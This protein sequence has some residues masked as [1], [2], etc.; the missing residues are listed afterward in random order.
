MNSSSVNKKRIL[1]GMRPSGKL[2]VGHYWGALVNW[3][4][5]QDEY[6]CFYMVADWH[7]LTSEY[8]DTKD[9][10]SNVREMVIDW[11]AI[12]LDPQKSVIFRQ[13]AVKQHAELF[14]LLSMI[15]PLPWLERCP[16]YK[17]QLRE[18]TTR[19]LSTYGFLGYPVLQA[20]DIMVYRADA[21]PVGEDQLAHLELTREIAR[22]FNNF[23]GNTFPEPQALLS[24]SPRVP[25]IDNRKMSKSYGNSI[26]LS[27]D[28]DAVRSKV[29]QMFTDPVKIKLNDKGHPEGCVVHAFYKIYI[30]SHEKRAAECKAGGTGCVACKK[31]LSE[32]LITALK[33]LREKR[34]VIAKDHAMV[35]VILKQGNEYACT[36]AEDTMKKVREAVKILG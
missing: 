5:Q 12:G 11:L 14:L 6:K 1:S 19:D 10:E 24:Q 7:A 30:E 17:E 3:V 2:H 23:Y 35:E 31:E 28:E 26:L 33:P 13:S 4:R 29:K 16:T 32:A 21:V 36:V 22:R 8:A 27:D 25:G 34:Q 18:V 20:A 9:I 15:T